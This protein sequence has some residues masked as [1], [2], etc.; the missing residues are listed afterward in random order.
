[1]Q[2]LSLAK[3]STLFTVDGLT[4]TSNGTYTVTY[5]DGI[6]TAV[7]LSGEDNDEQ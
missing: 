7:Y 1:M 4:F 2:R 5:S 6:T 3:G